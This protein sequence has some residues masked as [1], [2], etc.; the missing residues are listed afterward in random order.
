VAP[1]AEAFAAPRD[2]DYPH[3]LGLDGQLRFYNLASPVTLAGLSAHYG[4]RIIPD[5]SVGLFG[6]ATLGGAKRTGGEIDVRVFHVGLGADWRFVHVAP[7]SLT[8]RLRGAG[9]IVQL[10][11][12]AKSDVFAADSITGG[13]GSVMLALIPAVSTGRAELALPLELAFVFRAPRGLVESEPE[14]R[15]DGVSF[16]AAL[17]VTFGV[18]A[19]MGQRPVTIRAGAR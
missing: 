18:G 11:G 19:P 16:G 12:N 6:E 3:R 17:S 1:A 7:L 10:E 2:P 4:Y 8:G 9:S 15:V 14:L 13:T 5:V